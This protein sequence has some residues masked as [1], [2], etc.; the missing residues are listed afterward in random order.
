M[1]SCVC[2]NSRR[3][4]FSSG[5][6]AGACMRLRAGTLASPATHPLHPRRNCPATICPLQVGAKCRSCGRWMTGPAVNHRRRI[7][8][9]TPGRPADEPAGCLHSR[10]L[11]T[12]F[13]ARAR[14]HLP[15]RAKS[16]AN[17]RGNPRTRAAGWFGCKVCLVAVRFPLRHF[18]HGGCSSAG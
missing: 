13:P 2:K 6:K 16:P 11:L 17:Q 14:I 15:F 10:Q 9:L 4:R 8:V 18:A 12:G 3:E 5:T 7:F 1:R